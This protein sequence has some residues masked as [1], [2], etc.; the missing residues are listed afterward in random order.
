M[1]I[2][3]TIVNDSKKNSMETLK[4]TNKGQHIS[5]KLIL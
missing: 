4:T 3:F 5:I 2:I 1:K